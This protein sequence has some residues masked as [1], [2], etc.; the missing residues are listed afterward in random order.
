[1]VNKFANLET[2]VCRVA[3]RAT[4][5]N[6]YISEVLAILLQGGAIDRRTAE[7][8]AFACDDLENL[9]VALAEEFDLILTEQMRAPAV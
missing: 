9:A 4:V 8:V 1:M 5:A 2:Q 6:G 7:A 3:A